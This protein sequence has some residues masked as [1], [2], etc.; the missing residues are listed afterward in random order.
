MHYT[1]TRPSA[2][3]DQGLE[4]ATSG[5]TRFHADEPHFFSGFVENPH[6]VARGVLIVA[7]YAA[8]RFYTPVN[9]AALAA[10]DPVVTS[11]PEGL[12][13]ESFSGCCGAYARLDV[14]DLDAQS[15]Q[16]GVTNVDINTPLREALA[17]VTPGS[18][19]HLTIADDALH[20][21]TMDNALEE[22]KVNLP[23]RWVKG[24]AESQRL[25]STMTL[26]QELTGPEA[27][28]FIASLPGTSTPKSVQWVTRA[29]RG[30]RLA[31]RPSK[32]AV[33]LPGPER[34]KP[35]VPL[36]P[37][38]T[39]LSAYSTESDGSS[40]PRS[41]A[42]VVGLPGAR[43]TV[44][45][46]P[47]K[48]RGFSGEGSLLMSLSSRHAADDADLISAVLAFDPHIDISHLAAETGLTPDR[49][50]DALQVL[51]STGQVGYD[52]SLGAYFHRPLPL[53]PNVVGKLH[54][55]LSHA[56]EL[57]AG[58]AVTPLDGHNDE[59]AVCSGPNTYTVR[60]DDDASAF[61][62]TCFWFAKHKDSRGP[63][64]HVLAARAFRE[65]AH[66]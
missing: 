23:L 20:V 34:L 49:I 37:Y 54:T 64:K 16:S 10:L 66:E 55:R 58:N 4:L 30:F 43:F 46:S 8:K 21:T 47:M 53:D 1:Y 18:P 42:W 61:A 6:I 56:E 50:E 12:R 26:Q 22:K 19:L 63:C 48:T 57:L 40:Q 17:T 51:A 7:D 5:G 59:F 62:C 39:K 25:S 14:T 60:L 33:C 15:H 3:T 32:G 35:L 28:K 9:A 27:T 29:L 24:L 38:V 31:S 36:L 44:V 11:T 2:M 45:L 52:L 13:F 41:S 65:S